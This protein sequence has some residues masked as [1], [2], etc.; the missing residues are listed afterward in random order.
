MAAKER[1]GR[2]PGKLLQEPEPSGRTI[3][4]AVNAAINQGFVIGREVMVG[5]IPG[6]VV[7][8]NI[9]SFGQ[10]VGNA[11]PLVVRTALGV[12]KCGMDEVSLA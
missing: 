2:R 7:G 3:G 1:D 5:S 6:I 8:Y 12:A 9:A 10:F 4:S 11:Y